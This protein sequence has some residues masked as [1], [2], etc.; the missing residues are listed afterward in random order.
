MLKKVYSDYSECSKFRIR[1]DL[2]D[3]CQC[4]LDFLGMYDLIPCKVDYFDPS[5]GAYD[6]IHLFD[7]HLMNEISPSSENEDDLDSVHLLL[8]VKEKVQNFQ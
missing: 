7:K 6:S 5:T 3:E 8:Y 2:K 1:H 4:A